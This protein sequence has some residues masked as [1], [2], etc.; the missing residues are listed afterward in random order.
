[1]HTN[2]KQSNF[3]PGT[4]CGLL[5][6]VGIVCASCTAAACIG[7]ALQVA[8]IPLGVLIFSSS[9]LAIDVTSLVFS[10]AVL[11]RIKTRLCILS[12]AMTPIALLFVAYSALIT[13]EFG[14]ADRLSPVMAEQLRGTT[15]A[16]PYD[17]ICA[18][19]F[20]LDL[21]EYVF[22]DQLTLSLGVTVAKILCFGTAIFMWPCAGATPK[23]RVASR[24]N[25][26]SA[27]SKIGWECFRATP[28]PRTLS[29][30]SSGSASAAPLMRRPLASREKQI[31]SGSSVRSAPALPSV[32]QF[33]HDCDDGY[34]FDLLGY[35]LQHISHAPRRAPS[36]RNYLISEIWP[37][38]P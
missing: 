9:Y 37:G 33:K 36:G 12:I 8:T 38:A 15:K 35:R 31:F 29:V 11:W 26:R 20:G 6:G 34:V 24:H 2:T 7:R 30:S 25:D 3:W 19:F 27:R 16:N 17:A 28:L 10:V 1:M 14:L 5:I 4:L 18:S 23:D 22:W 21:V 13:L 32:N